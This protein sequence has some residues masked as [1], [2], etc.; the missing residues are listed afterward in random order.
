[1]INYELKE[2]LIGVGTIIFAIYLSFSVFLMLMLISNRITL[3]WIDD[4]EPSDK[5]YTL[6]IITVILFW[7]FFLIKS[8]ISKGD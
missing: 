3:I 6:M 7:P 5:E 8:K 1:M 2:F 4:K